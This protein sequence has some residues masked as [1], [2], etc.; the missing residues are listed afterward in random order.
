MGKRNRHGVY[1]LA[2]FVAV[3]RR[4]FEDFFGRA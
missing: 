3:N 2:P 4:N 1:Q